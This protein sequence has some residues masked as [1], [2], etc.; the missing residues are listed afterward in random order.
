MGSDGGI[1]FYKALQV[2]QYAGPWLR[3]VQNW[4]ITQEFEPR[5]EL[6]GRWGRWWPRPCW[7]NEL[8]KPM[9]T[10]IVSLE[11]WLG[12]LGVSGP[13]SMSL[14]FI[15]E[16]YNSSTYLDIVEAGDL[17]GLSEDLLC[18]SYGTNVPE[19]I[20]D[21]IEILEYG[22]PQ[23]GWGVQP[24]PQYWPDAYDAEGGRLWSWQKETWT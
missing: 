18:L 19:G 22:R 12:E 11:D 5:P 17:P 16:H 3:K 21:L 10:K 23:L 9:P 2:G 20:G 4:F 14:R 24:G 13:D 8:Q 6:G 7:S 1:I 15:V